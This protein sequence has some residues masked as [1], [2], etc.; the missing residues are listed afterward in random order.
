MAD[1]EVSQAEHPCRWARAGPAV[2]VALLFVGPACA[3]TA[4]E[5]EV[6][7]TYLYKLA[8]FVEWPPTAFGS[9]GA[10]VTVCVVGDD[11]FGVVLDRAVE[12]KSRGARPIVARHLDR[13]GAD[14]G[15]QIMYIA[16]SRQQ[17]V[18]EALRAVEGAPVLTVTDSEPPDRR[19]MVNFVLQDNRIRFQIDEAAAARNGLAMS[20]KL[21]ELAV[22]VRRKN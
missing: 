17:S 16:G 1:A 12:G 7:A 14:S 20:A 10:P 21:L 13:A 6:K 3:E 22:S 9:P 8:P 18:G 2:V 11:R 15:C 19:G 5:R 4:L